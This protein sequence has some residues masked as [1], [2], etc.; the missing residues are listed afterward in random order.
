[1]L[2]ESLVVRDLRVYL[3]RLGGRVLHYR[4]SNQHEVVVILQ[5]DD[6][7]WAAVEVKLGTASVDAAAGL[8]EKFM[9]A[10]I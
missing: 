6:G 2:F 8:L 5:A 4:D 1:L 3:Q 9:Q 7:R 10:W